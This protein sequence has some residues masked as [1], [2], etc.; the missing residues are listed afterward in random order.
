[1][2]DLIVI[3][4]SVTE[5][6]AH[7]IIDSLFRI[8]KESIAQTTIESLIYLYTDICPPTGNSHGRRHFDGSDQRIGTFMVIV[9]IEMKTV[10]KHTQV[11]TDILIQSTLP[12]QIRIPESGD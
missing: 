10:G 6:N 11:Q 2:S 1:M 4:L 9:E 8:V 3:S 5:I 7:G 12:F